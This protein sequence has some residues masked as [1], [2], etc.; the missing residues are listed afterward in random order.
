MGA[1]DVVRYH[2]LEALRAATTE[3]ER[4]ARRL[5]AE[6]MMRLVSMTEDELWELARVTC[7]PQQT[8]EQAYAIFKETIE[9]LKAS[10]CE[11][12]KDLETRNTGNQTVSMEANHEQQLP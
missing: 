2:L 6:T 11:W 7:L 5:R 8:F 9:N 4:L 10:S 1:S 12:M 3:D